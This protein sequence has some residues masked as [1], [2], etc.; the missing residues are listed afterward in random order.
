TADKRNGA[1]SSVYLRTDSTKRS[2]GRIKTR[3]VCANSPETD[4][5]V[6]RL[7]PSRPILL[8]AYSCQCCRIYCSQ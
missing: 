8:P 6:L 7:F 4:V 3:M 1:L 5:R 2:S